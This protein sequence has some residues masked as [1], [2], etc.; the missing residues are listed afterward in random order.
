M[1]GDMRWK[2]LGGGEGGA[3]PGLCDAPVRRDQLKFTLAIH[4]A[5]PV[6]CRAFSGHGRRPRTDLSARKAQ[7]GIS[8]AFYGQSA[9]FLVMAAW[10][11]PAPVPGQLL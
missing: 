5:L 7:K 1:R 4:A 2:G 3:D 9:T 10:S 11:R 8:G 6:S